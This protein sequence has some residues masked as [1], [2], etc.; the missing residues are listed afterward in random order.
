MVDY[1]LCSG[2]GA[3]KN[4]CPKKCI[5]MEKD[6]YGFYKARKVDGCVE[7]GICKRTCPLCSVNVNKKFSMKYYALKNKNKIAKQLSSSGGVFVLLAKY[8][9]ENG[10]SVYGASFDKKFNV[11]HIRVTSLNELY[12]IIGSK[13]VQSNTDNVY[14]DVEQDLKKNKIV[15]FSGT[16]CQISGLKNMLKKNY[17]N[18]YTIEILC[19]GIPSEKV[20]ESYKKYLCN[21]YNS[22]INSVSFRDKKYG[23][24]AYSMKI[25]FENGREY[26]KIV[27]NDMYMQS[28]LRGYNILESCHNCHYK[29]IERIGDITLGDLWGVSIKEFKN[30]IEEGVSLA[31]INSEKGEVLL[32]EIKDNCDIIKIKDMQMKNVISNMTGRAEIASKESR[33][34]FFEI[35]N[36]QDDF[37]NAYKMVVRGSVLFETK[38]KIKGIIKIALFRI[39]TLKIL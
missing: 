23:W 12:K 13:Y 14:N 16:G 10:G 5:V 11:E 7:C 18:L 34:K 8:I 27:D 31:S 9:L 21:K 32:C 30:E 26:V 15:L 25:K 37:F 20:W 24:H 3:C 17:S 36:N 2:C 38:M 35:I 6:S 33:K 28:Y 4:S 22:N 29:E 39:K 19:H 1:E